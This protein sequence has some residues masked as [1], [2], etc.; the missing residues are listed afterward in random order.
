MNA[1]SF[2]FTVMLLLLLPAIWLGCGGEGDDD[3][4]DAA[5]DDDDATD[6]DGDDDETICPDADNDGFT[7]QACG[8]EDCNDS[9][10]S[11]YP[12]A[13]EVC[14]DEVDQ[15]CDG[16]ADDGC[17]YWRDETVLAGYVAA[18]M[19]RE[20]SLTFLSDGAP[21]IAYY[22]PVDKN[23][24]VAVRPEKDGDWM[25]T[26]ID[27]DGETGLYSSIDV[28]SGDRLG[29]AYFEATEKDLR[30]AFLEPGGAWTVQTVATDGEIG[31]HAKLRFN[32]LDEP[33]IFAAKRNAWYLSHYEYV[34]DGWRFAR[35]FNNE[36]FSSKYPFDV[37]IS[38]IG[39]PGFAWTFWDDEEPLSKM[40]DDYMYI[41]WHH[42]LYGWDAMQLYRGNLIDVDKR[43]CATAWTGEDRP[44]G[45]FITDGVP[46]IKV[47]YFNGHDWLL[48]DLDDQE[49]AANGPLSADTD[50]EG[51]VWLAYYDYFNGSPRVARQATNLSWEFENVFAG[52]KFG[53]WATLKIAPDD[54]PA[55]VFYDETTSA[56]R[57]AK[58]VSIPTVE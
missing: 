14:G 37:K 43:F 50:S 22:H 48:Y 21:V 34:D 28:D 13:D 49:A 30:A 18:N 53:K 2:W 7:D 24:A 31:L 41:G 45:F 54:Q 11:I 47:G 32:H 42:P 56:L 6:D 52:E 46:I 38:S 51:I 12:G 10:G 8:G 29:I 23:L 3:D 1:K 19:N 57:Y 15:D 35:R 55:L 39:F 25:H 20:Y 26:V 40:G 33:Q 16:T 4:D 36:S 5:D 44:F 27:G 58:R 9:A 17:T